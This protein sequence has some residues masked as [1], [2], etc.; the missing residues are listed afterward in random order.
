MGQAFT[1]WA[2]GAIPSQITAEKPQLLFLMCHPP[3]FFLSFF[4]PHPLSF[5][6]Q[7]LS[8]A[9][10][11]LDCLSRLAVEAQ[12]FPA[13]P[14]AGITTTTTFYF[15]IATEVCNPRVTLLIHM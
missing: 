9:W 6:R 1:H 3:F 12:R 10:I 8:M 5:L 15:Y 2:M 14:C 13:S 11:S 7:H 4:P